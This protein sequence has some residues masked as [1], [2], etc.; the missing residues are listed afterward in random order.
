[1]IIFFTKIAQKLL[2]Y[3]GECGIQ[4]LLT[5]RIEKLVKKAFELRYGEAS[6]GL[7]TLLANC[8]FFFIRN[9]DGAS[10]SALREAMVSFFPRIRATEVPSTLF[11]ELNSVD[12]CEICINISTFVLN[13]YEKVSDGFLIS[14]FDKL[15][16][17]AGKFHRFHLI[18][19]SFEFYISFPEEIIVGNDAAR[20]LYED[21][22]VNLVAQLIHNSDRAPVLLEIEKRLT[23]LIL[24]GQ[25]LCRGFIGLDIWN[26]YFRWAVRTIRKAFFLFLVNPQTN[27][28][29]PSCSLFWKVEQ[30]QRHVCFQ[31]TLFAKDV[32]QSS[33]AKSLSN[34]KPESTNRNSGKASGRR[35]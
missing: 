7:S 33:I 26:V 4:E 32:H 1:M 19:R 22:L 29:K 2:L 24:S 6:F 28:V 20:D 30:T 23:S 14:L 15:T 34:L 12:K 9:I 27:A 8:V 13:S 5:D 11:A 35:S 31:R 21:I 10:Q 25:R 16:D 17:I 3:F 18:V